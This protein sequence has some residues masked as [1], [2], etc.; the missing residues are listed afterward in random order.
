MMLSNLNGILASTLKQEAAK[1]LRFEST[2]VERGE[3][4]SLDDYIARMVPEQED[5][6]Y[7]LAAPSRESA[8]ASAYMEAC[9]ANKVEVL[10]LTSTIDEFVMTNLN[11][12]AGKT[13]ESAENAKLV[14]KPT[15]GAEKLSS[16]D[17]E[18]LF[19]WLKDSV[20]QIKEVTLSTRLAD[21]PAMIVGHES[22]SMRRMM[23]MM[24]A[25][26]A[27]QLP[28]QKLEVNGSHPIIRG[29]AV[30]RDSQPEVA[31][32]IAVQVYSNALI[33]AGLMDDPRMMLSNLNG[34][35][36]STLGSHTHS[37]AGASTATPSEHAKAP[38]QASEKDA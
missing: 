35:L 29:L 9:A 8:M 2:S 4:V 34:I 3:L 30:A 32:M 28:P 17:A 19:S 33:A 20:P 5:K 11:I 13:L 12:Y 36:A 31:K 26:R 18:A 14:L 27:P 22:A 21:S 1:L 24:E 15:E 16:A 6:I 37:S 10:L 38:E 23:A 7:Y 25:G